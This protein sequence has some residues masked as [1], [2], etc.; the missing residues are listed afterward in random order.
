MVLLGK[1]GSSESATNETIRRARTFGI[2]NQIPIVLICEARPVK[3]QPADSVLIRK[4][5]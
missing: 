2:G 5:A 1:N 3:D 4:E